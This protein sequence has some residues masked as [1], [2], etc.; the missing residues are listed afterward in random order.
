MKKISLFILAVILV[1]VFV[2]AYTSFLGQKVV[3][4]TVYDCSTNQPI[5]GATV[6]ARQQGWGWDS[7]LVWDKNYWVTNQSDA[8][9]QFTI[10]FTHGRSANLWVTKEGY[11]TALQYEYPSQAVRVGMVSGKGSDFSQNCLPL[12]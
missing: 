2:A 9:G 4:G 6:T 5:A 8:S 12:Q 1:V 7:Y 3:A 11:L 10:R